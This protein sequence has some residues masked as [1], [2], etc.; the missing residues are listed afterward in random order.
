MTSSSNCRK[1]QEVSRTVR[2]ARCSS[3]VAYLAM[4]PDNS[5]DRATRN[6]FEEDGQELGR[7]LHACQCRAE[8]VDGRGSKREKGQ[9]TEVQHDVRM[10]QVLQELDLG[11]E[12][13]DHALDPL[14]LLV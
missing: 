14:I 10:V 3:R 4:R 2:T 7:L 6:V 11:F 1:D 8:L 13:R 9:L 5:S 12:R